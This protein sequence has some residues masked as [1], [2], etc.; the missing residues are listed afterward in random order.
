MRAD[1]RLKEAQFSS[2]VW[3]TSLTLA[4]LGIALMGAGAALFGGLLALLK[5]H[6][7]IG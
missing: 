4:G 5:W 2:E 1:T 3:R 7:G 6:Y